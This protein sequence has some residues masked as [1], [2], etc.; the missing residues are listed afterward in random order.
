MT[1]RLYE[2]EGDLLA[3][4]SLLME[5]R[6][7]T[8]DWHYAHVGEFLF[9]FLMVACHLDPHEHVR[10]WHDDS[11]RLIGYAILGEDPALDWQ[12]LPEFE[13]SGLEAEAM[14]WAE[15]S[16]AEL[17]LHDPAGWGGPLVSGARRDNPRRIA[18]LEEHG[19]RYS[20][21]FAEVNHLRS[22]A[23]P[24]PEPAIPDGCLVRALADGEIAERAAAHRD[25]WLPWSDGNVSTEDYARLMRLPG[26]ERDLDVV[27]VTPDGTIAAFVQGWLD[28]V[29][30]IGDLGEVGARP[31][32]RRR[33]FTRAVLLE[34]M[35]RMRARGMERVCVSTGETNDAARPL[36]ESIGFRVDN[37]YLDFVQ[38]DSKPEA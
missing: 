23:E 8:G 32:Y 3:M 24:I 34:C 15:A 18:F 5:A 36:Y 17:R 9:T 28:P 4:R 22:L 26:Y 16:V 21:R 38:R 14:A 1:S 20:G 10:L 12:V 27:A 30:R 13:W 6:S 7:R 31:A 25:V 35:R 19:F 11:G 33:G 29:N 2:G 37:R